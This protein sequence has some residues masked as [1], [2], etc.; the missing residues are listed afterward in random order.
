MKDALN[1]KAVPDYHGE[2]IHQV[3]MSFHVEHPTLKRF[4]TSKVV[5]A[6]P[7]LDPPTNYSHFLSRNSVTTL[8]QIDCNGCQDGSLVIMGCADGSLRWASTRE[9]S[10]LWSGFSVCVSRS[11]VTAMARNSQLQLLLIGS[12]D[13]GIAIVNNTNSKPD[14]GFPIVSGVKTSPHVDSITAIAVDLEGSDVFC[15]GTP[16]SG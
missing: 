12:S 11:P 6:L 4:Q 8:S 3:G 5:N 7:L 15:S 10:D 1:Q 16:S 14:E 9:A 2:P 13:G